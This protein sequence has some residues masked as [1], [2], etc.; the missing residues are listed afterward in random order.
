MNNFLLYGATG[1]TGELLARE[2]ARRGLRPVLAGRNAARVE[3]LAQELGLEFRVFALEDTSRL[4]DALRDVAVV[5]H[6]A[7]PFSLTAAPMVAACLRTGTHYLDITGEISVFEDLARQHE[8]ATTAG[9]LLLP[10]VGFDVVPSDC[11][12]RHLKERLPTATH[13][14]LAFQ[15]LGPG[16]VSHG[17]QATM[18]LN[19]GSG[20][21]VRRQGRIVPVPAAWKTRPIDFGAGPILATTIPWG[22][23]STAF[24]S[25]QIPNIEVYTVLPAR[26][27]RMLRLSRYLGPVLRSGPVQRYLLSRLAPGGPSATRR[28]QA[29]TALYGEATDDQG[30]R[31]AARLSAPEGYTLTVLTALLITEK[32]LAGHWKPGFRTPASA[33]GAELILEVEGVRREDVE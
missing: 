11:L 17:T 31:V 25:T 26:V 32:V 33:Y 15:A 1:Y 27:R 3:A 16:G 6:C 21:A 2:A 12:A 22:D 9:I 28:A 10:G 19:A 13:L 7:G 29:R 5:L 20:G 24:Y 23:V 4:D 14:T 8:A 18:L 30:R